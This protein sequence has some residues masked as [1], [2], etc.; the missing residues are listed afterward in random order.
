MALASS[1]IVTRG[2]EEAPQPQ[3]QERTVLLFF[4]AGWCPDCQ[5][6]TS[7]LIAAMIAMIALDLVQ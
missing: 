1:V 5:V 7:C 4:G 6:T 2:G 3:P